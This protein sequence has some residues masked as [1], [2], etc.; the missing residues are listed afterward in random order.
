MSLSL[1]HKCTSQM[2][3]REEEANMRSAPETLVGLVC[4]GNQ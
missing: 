4:E 3:L 1:S 2:V